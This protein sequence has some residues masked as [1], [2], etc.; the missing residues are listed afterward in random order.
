MG[1][2]GYLHAG[3]RCLEDVV[4]VEQKSGTKFGNSRGEARQC[5]RSP[6]LGASQ[7]YFR[8]ENVDNADGANCGFMLP[9][10][11]REKEGDL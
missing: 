6:S 10:K 8:Q 3:R 9:R 2:N 4:G 5:E 11:A 7:T 1:M